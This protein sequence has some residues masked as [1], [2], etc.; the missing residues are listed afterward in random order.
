MLLIRML[1][2]YSLKTRTLQHEKNQNKM[3]KKKKNELADLG[4]SS[5]FN[6]TDCRSNYERATQTERRRSRI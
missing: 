3:A 4:I 2:C 5:C 6:Y 1:I